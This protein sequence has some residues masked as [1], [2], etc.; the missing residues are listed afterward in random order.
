MC[1][2]VYVYALSLYMI[3]SGLNTYCVIVKTAVYLILVGC[4]KI[5]GF[6]WIIENRESQLQ[7]FLKKATK[8][9]NTEP[10]LRDSTD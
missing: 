3:C 6:I 9:N 5:E 4:D 8:I 1:V 2:Y 7:H 10:T